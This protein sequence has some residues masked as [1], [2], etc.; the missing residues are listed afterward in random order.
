MSADT[1]ELISK[2]TSDSLIDASAT[3]YPSRM[4]ALLGDGHG[5][6]EFG[7]PTSSF[8]GY[9]VDGSA[10]I[11]T[12]TLDVTGQAGTF[13]AAPGPVRVHASGL[14]VVIERFGYRCLPL[15]G[16]IEARGR[17]S[18]IDGCSDSVLVAP[19]RQG[20]PVLNSLHF[21]AGIRQSVHSHPS[22]RLGVV[23][24]GEGIAFGP[25][26]DGDWRVALHPGAMFLLPAHEMHAFST[27]E[28][29]S[30]LDVIAFHPDSD[31]G[32]TDGTHPMLNRT[33]LR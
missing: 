16:G 3:M 7:N 32:P 9:V 5:D 12:R 30:S 6:K 13:F 17:L 20:D 18:Y 26:P 21:P 2:P 25:G 28:S 10:R 33:Y 27:V 15:L 24:R 1:M 11:E 4:T 29:K 22:I 14:V 31:W 8:Y 19:A 23:A